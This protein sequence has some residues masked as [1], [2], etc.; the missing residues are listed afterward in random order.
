MI[1]HLLQDGIRLKVEFVEYDADSNVSPA[2]RLEGPRFG[3]CV[4]GFISVL[5][6]SLFSPLKYIL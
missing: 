2:G 4:S 3:L 5:D 1:L 6:C